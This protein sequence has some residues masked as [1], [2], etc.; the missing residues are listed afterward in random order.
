[1][2]K[3]ITGFR[4]A[5][6]MAGAVLMG[7]SSFGAVIYD[8]TEIFTGR[9][10]WEGNAEIGDVVG[11]G[12]TDRILTDF[13]FEYFLSPTAS[14]NEMGQIFFRALD[15]PIV[16]GVNLPGTL[17][18]STPA[19]SLRAT[20][21]GYDQI[22]LTGLLL[23]VPED[24]IA[25]TVAFSGLEGAEEAGLLFYQDSDYVGTNPTFF[26]AEVGANVDYMI[27][28]QADGT[29][30]LL[31]HE[32]E[33]DRLN[34]RFTAVPEPTTWAIMLGGLATLGFLRRRKS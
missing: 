23:D 33:L 11:F 18:Y 3:T 9:R 22:N 6:C 4:T 10:T 14:G 25:W 1:M 5:A 20:P 27:R 30:D 16:N 8:N 29:W 7:A 15:G 19:F 34:V 31:N 12:G 13:Q 17:I 24:A 32:P 21:D 26:D 2:Q 28:R